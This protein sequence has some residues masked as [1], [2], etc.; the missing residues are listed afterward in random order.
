M[1]LIE[2]PTI[3]P[4]PRLLPH[5]RSPPTPR[6][7]SSRPAH[8]R[9]GVRQPLHLLRT[10]QNALISPLCAAPHPP[11]RTM[12]ALAAATQTLQQFCDTLLS[13]IPR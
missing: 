11:A 10:A 4:Q 7:A 8:L 5:C 2:R 9:T 6:W 3:A 13:V 1:L 12:A